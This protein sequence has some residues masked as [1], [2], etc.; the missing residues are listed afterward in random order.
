[1]HI[2]FDRAEVQISG[3]IMRKEFV[4]MIESAESQ[5]SLSTSNTL[6]LGVR[7]LP[8]NTYGRE[9]S[10]FCSILVKSAT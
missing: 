9:A 4:W 5:A 8:S 10:W 1:M 7:F 6:D 2:L 3:Q